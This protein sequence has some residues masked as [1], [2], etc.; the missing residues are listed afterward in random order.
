M[1]QTLFVVWLLFLTSMSVYT[2][3]TTVARAQQTDAVL[4]GGV[5]GILIRYGSIF[6]LVYYGGFFN[7]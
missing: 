1:F 4:Y 3:I 5:V 2:H 7:P 6:A